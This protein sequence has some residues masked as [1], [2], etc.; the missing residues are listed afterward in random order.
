M[1]SR[2]TLFEDSQ[3]KSFNFDIVYCFLFTHLFSLVTLWFEILIIW[4][5]IIT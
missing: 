5:Q 3:R 4:L 1:G 2:V